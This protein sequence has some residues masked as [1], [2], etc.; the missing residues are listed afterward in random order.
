MVHI[1]S[2]VTELPP[3]SGIGLLILLRFIA[4]YVVYA[5]VPPAVILG[6]GYVL[7]RAV[8]EAI[9]REREL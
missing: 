1:E 9:E 8:S 7:W 3:I 4:I 5:V 6:I 2:L